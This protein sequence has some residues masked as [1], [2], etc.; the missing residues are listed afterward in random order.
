[1]AEPQHAPQARQHSLRSR[2]RMTFARFENVMDALGEALKLDLKIGSHCS[3]QFVQPPPPLRCTE[4]LDPDLQRFF[5]RIYVGQN[6]LGDSDATALQG[7]LQCQPFVVEVIQHHRDTGGIWRRCV[8][9]SWQYSSA[10]VGNSDLLIHSQIA[11]R[12]P[13]DIWPELASSAARS[14]KRISMG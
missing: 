7:P 4:V 12:L 2:V 9:I 3:H 5:D 10:I 11:A 14:T 6:F 1:V 8:F 13:R